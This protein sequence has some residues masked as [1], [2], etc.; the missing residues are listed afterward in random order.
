[1]GSEN[2]RFCQ[3]FLKNCMKSKEFGC[4]VGGAS[5][6]FALDPPMIPPCEFFLQFLTNFC[7]FGQL[8]IC[9]Q[10]TTNLIFTVFSQGV[11]LDNF[12]GALSLFPRRCLQRISDDHGKKTQNYLFCSKPSI[13][14]R[15]FSLYFFI[16]QI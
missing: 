9:L 5:P 7:S 11:D 15:T 8:Q 2:T 14:I 10:N 3:N 6:V 13:Y 16:Y 12:N 4:Q 1:M